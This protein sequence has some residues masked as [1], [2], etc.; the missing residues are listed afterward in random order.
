M[1]RE[2]S[3]EFCL[4]L[5]NNGSLCL[6][7]TT[8][9][10][11][12]NA[13]PVAWTVPAQKAPPVVAMFLSPGHLTW[14]NIARTGEFTLNV[15]GKDLLKQ[16]AYL[17]GITGRQLDKLA[18][19][20][21]FAAR[22]KTVAAPIFPDCLGHLECRLVYLDAETHLVRAEVRYALADEEAFYERWKLDGG[23]FPLQHLGGEFYQCGGELL[24]Q[25]RLKSWPAS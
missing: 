12:F 24:V 21:L 2:L 16:V 14:E 5:L 10:G 3:S 7:G 6:V 9:E 22:G 4:R 19:C 8:G 13:A 18:A 23:I 1:K 20:G 11:G 25:P 17:G 15:P